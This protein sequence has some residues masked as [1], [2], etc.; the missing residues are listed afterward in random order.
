MF[1]IPVAIDDVTKLVFYP[2]TIES[3]DADKADLLF[4]REL[5]LS[6]PQDF[7]SY[8]CV[9]LSDQRVN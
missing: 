7:L 9:T 4:L 1:T 5:P 3:D 6:S 8:A 2:C